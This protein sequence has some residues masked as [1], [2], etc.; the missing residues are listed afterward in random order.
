MRTNGN[1]VAARLGECGEL[2]NGV[3]FNQT[4]EGVGLPVLKVKDFGDLV[5]MPVDGLDELN[6]RAIA[7]PRD[8]YLS[9]GDVV[10]IR[11]NGNGELV[12]RSLLVRG[13]LRPTTFSGFCIRFRPNVQRIDP[14]YAAYFIRSPICRQRFTA[15]GSG[16][17]IQNLNQATISDVEIDLPSLE[18]QK[19]IA[20]VLGVLDDKIELNRRMNQTLE[21]LARAMFKSWFVDFDPVVAK[22]AGKKPVGMS[23]QTAALFP[24]RFQD[25][26]LGPIPKDWRVARV[27][28]EFKLTMGQSPPGDTYN[29]D[30]NG[31]PFFQGRTDFTFRFPVR[32][33]YCT[34]PTRFADPQDTLVSVRAPVGDINMAIERCAV[35]RGV[36][37]V[38]HRSGDRSLTYYAMWAL[39]DAFAMFDGDGTLFGS[40]GKTDFEGIQYVSP[41]D[42]V[43]GQFTAMVSPLD[44]RIEQNERQSASLVSLRD[45][46]LPRLMSGELRI[47]Q[48]EGLMEEV[49]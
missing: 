36:A 25:S 35:G 46:L 15:F 44:D 34:A 39:S 2:R 43:L 24:D 5:L 37:A 17:G 6:P 42:D 1:W 11:S 49:V 16:T 27:G 18:E 12:G 13:L 41:P 4:Q 8:Q 23:A 9:E 48:A 14:R 45:A 7:I 28:D 33:V 3:N 22:A 29:E 10:I 47:Y 21:G 31:S 40:I 38:R 32:R 20:R 30:R 26:A 19:A